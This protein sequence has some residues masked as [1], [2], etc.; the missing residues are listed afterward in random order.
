MSGKRSPSCSEPFAAVFLGEKGT[1]IAYAT[2]TGYLKF[3]GFFYIFI[4]LKQT[5]DGVLRGLGY[6]KMFMIANLVNLSIRVLVAMICAPRF[7]IGFIWYA[8]PLGWL[9][10]FIISYSEYHRRKPEFLEMRPSKLF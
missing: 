5:T 3:I 7:G 1:E 10:N 2:A 8:V 6:M 9:A 4:G